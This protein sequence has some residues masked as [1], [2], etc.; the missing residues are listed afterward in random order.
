MIS[1]ILNLLSGGLLK[2][3]EA[4]LAADSS[5]KSLIADAAIQDIKAQMA[6][7]DA[8]KEIRLSTVGFWEMRVATALIAWTVSAHMALIGLDTIL[9]TVNLGIPPL[10]QPMQEWEAQIILSLFGLQAAQGGISAIASAIRG[11]K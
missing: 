11:R 10:P 1:A 3:W 7:R 6:A 4:K 2:A 9:T 5:E 8:A